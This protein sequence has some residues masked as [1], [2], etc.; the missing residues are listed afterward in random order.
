MRIESSSPSP[1][2]KW[3]DTFLASM[4]QVG[5]PL[6]DATIAKIFERCQIQRV[7]QLL[8]TLIHN[9]DIPPEGLDA[10]IYDYLRATSIVPAV[11]ADLI[12]EG[13]EF[14]VKHGNLAL[15]VLVCASLPEC[16][17]LKRGINVLWLTQRLEEHVLRRLLETADMVIS[18]M[19]VGG[20]ERGGS[21]FRTRP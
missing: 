18:V 5:D 11:N 8:T 2:E 20:L 6:A 17:V 13:Q 10:E 9:D 4:R 3:P 16:Y 21:G 19:S 7:N 14:F 12:R 15:F 1:R